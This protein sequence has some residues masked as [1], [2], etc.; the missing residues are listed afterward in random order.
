MCQL[1]IV[2]SLSIFFFHG[3]VLNVSL[4]NPYLYTLIWSLP[5]ES[6][7]RC[8]LFF[9]PSIFMI[10]PTFETLIT[11]ALMQRQNLNKIETRIDV[12]AMILVLS[13][14]KQMFL[15][16]EIIMKL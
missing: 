15:T 3:W 13:R 1:K 11:I 12:Y 16:S 4:S 8:V 6:K 9:P 5:R 7:S 14:V 2:S 10:P